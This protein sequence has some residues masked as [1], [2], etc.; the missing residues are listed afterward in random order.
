MNISDSVSTDQQSVRTALKYK[1]TKNGRQQEADGKMREAM[2]TNSGTFVGKLK[3]LQ[4]TNLLSLNAL[5]KCR[6]GEAGKGFA[7][8]ADESADAVN[9]TRNPDQRIT[10]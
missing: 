10:R 7:V 8:V 1:R 6:A 4:A 9:T 2:E 3:I 5:L